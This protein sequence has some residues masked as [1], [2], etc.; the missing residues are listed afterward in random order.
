M[1]E[2]RLRAEFPVLRNCDH[3]YNVIYN[4]LPLSL[5]GGTDRFRERADLRLDFTLET[6]RELGEIL[7]ACLRDV[8]PALPHTTGHEKR[9]VE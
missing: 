4:S 5:I 9:G 1:L 3:C 8:R 6:G 7:R 2:D